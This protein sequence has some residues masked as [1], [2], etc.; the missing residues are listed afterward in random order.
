MPCG[1]G[2]RDGGALFVQR[3]AT[4]QHPTLWL[5]LPQP[6]SHRRNPAEVFQYVLL[7][8]ESHGDHTPGRERDRGAEDIFQ[9]EDAL[10]VVP[11][12]PVPEVSHVGFGAIEP[13]VQP[14]VFMSFA[15]VLLG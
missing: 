14:E 15:A 1:S 8:D 13:L 10:T 5:N 6:V 3:M 9:H 11:E 2:G 4:S 7:A 12:G